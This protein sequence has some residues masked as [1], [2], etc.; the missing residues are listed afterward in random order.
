MLK[1]TI[2]G[3]SLDPACRCACQSTWRLRLSQT[4]LAS[5]VPLKRTQKLESDEQLDQIIIETLYTYVYYYLFSLLN[6]TGVSSSSGGFWGPKSLAGNLQAGQ[7]F[8][9]IAEAQVILKPRKSSLLAEFQDQSLHDFLFF[10]LQ[11]F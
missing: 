11:P 8:E 4:W 5:H 7:S 6:G 10:S 1:R 9:T 3:K 2:A